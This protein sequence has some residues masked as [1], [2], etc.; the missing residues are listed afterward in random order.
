MFYILRQFWLISWTR[1]SVPSNCIKKL[2][3]CKFVDVLNHLIGRKKTIFITQITWKVMYK[4][5]WNRNFNMRKIKI[6]HIYY[7]TKNFVWWF[8]V[9]LQ[10][11]KTSVFN[12]EILLSEV[13]LIDFRVWH[14]QF[15]C[16]F[17]GIR[18]PDQKESGSARHKAPDPNPWAWTILCFI[19]SFH[20][21]ALQV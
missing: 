4:S 11:L 8:L 7:S 14:F 17:R 12:S 2:Y 18:I 19:Y 16:I 5:L 3:S 10:V 13:L 1:D 9:L 20:L 21:Q 15:T 6:G